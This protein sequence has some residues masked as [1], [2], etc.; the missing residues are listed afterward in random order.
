MELRKPLSEAV[1][2]ADR[3]DAE[4]DMFDSLEAHCTCSSGTPPPCG[5]PRQHLAYSCWGCWKCRKFHGGP[6][7]AH[8][9]TESGPVWAA[10]PPR[11]DYGYLRLWRQLYRLLLRLAAAAL[12]AVPPRHA[13]RRVS[14]D[15]LLHTLPLL[16][17]PVAHP[18][19]D[20]D[21][22]SRSNQGIHH[23][24]LCGY[25]VPALLRRLSDVSGAGRHG[26]LRGRVNVRSTS[27]QRRVNV[28]KIRTDEMNEDLPTHAYA[29]HGPHFD[30]HGGQ[31]PGH[32]APHKG[33]LLHAVGDTAQQARA[34]KTAT[35]TL[36]QTN[37]HTHIEV[38]CMRGD[39]HT[40]HQHEGKGMTR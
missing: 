14:H 34:T 6:T 26:A 29:T 17:H 4:A 7:A 8:R 12:R 5:L 37:K 18:A 1:F 13:P 9:G 40:S 23:R 33:A 11:L 36:Q 20:Q 28:T 3:R 2:A 21:P 25:P 24:G 27:G 39:E 38:F 31:P 22:H 16:L 15:A 30:P 35:A 19:Q 32:A 10:G